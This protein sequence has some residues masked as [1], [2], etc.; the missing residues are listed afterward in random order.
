LYLQF[1]PILFSLAILLLGQQPYRVPLHP[2][3][4]GFGFGFGLGFG[5]GIGGLGL[6]I[7]T[8]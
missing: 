6:L 3:I 7:T 1:V 4:N 2:P 5:G 8:I